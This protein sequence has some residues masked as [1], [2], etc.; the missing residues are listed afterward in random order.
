MATIEELLRQA[1]GVR[2]DIG[3]GANKQPNFIGI[4]VQE[5]PGVDIVH[6]VNIHPWPLPDE[7]A[8]GAMCSHLVEHI[9]PVAFR[10]DGRT[11]FPFIEFMDEVWR[12]LKPDGQ[13]AI[14][15]PHGWSAGYLQDPTHCNALNEN[16]WYYFDPDTANGLL[17]S[18][19]KPKPWKVETLYWDLSA[20]MEVILRKIG[21][22]DNKTD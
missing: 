20:N 12:I 21:K 4:D 7:C 15:C 19:Y 13:F 3:C 8:T 17:Y 11:W 14:S 1:A 18:F 9:P 22:N 6:D 10:P 2:L 16:T 5:L